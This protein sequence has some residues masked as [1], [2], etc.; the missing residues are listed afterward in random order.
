MYPYE[1]KKCRYCDTDLPLHKF[2]CPVCGRGQ[3]IAYAVFIPLFVVL[4]TAII[5]IAYFIMPDYPKIETNESSITSSASSKKTIDNKTNSEKSISSSKSLTSSQDIKVSKKLFGD[6]KITIPKEFVLEGIDLT[7]SETQKKNGL[8]SI[9]KNSDGSLVYTIKGSKYNDF[10]EEMRNECQKSY[11]KML[12]EGSFASLKSVKIDKNFNKITVT[13]D[14]SAYTD[15]FDSAAKL[16]F[17]LAGMFYQKFDT[18][19]SGKVTV[20]VI[21]Q[22]T[23]E[24]IDKGIYPDD[25]QDLIESLNGLSQE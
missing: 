22:T 24:V 3:P 14:K 23:K 7:V 4:I 8:K 20:E 10:L 5:V 12:A 15:S 9:E 6:V 18:N 17:G 19:A 11:D 25:A 1:T 16:G 21:D 2:K 13:A